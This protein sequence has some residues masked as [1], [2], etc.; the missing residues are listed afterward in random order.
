MSTVFMGSRCKSWNQSGYIIAF[1]QWKRSVFAL[2]TPSHFWPEHCNCN[3]LPVP[4]PCRTA[5]WWKS[6]KRAQRLTA[7][8]L[9][10][11]YQRAD[12]A[13]FALVRLPFSCM[14]FFLFSNQITLSL[15]LCVPVIPLTWAVT[16]EYR[17]S[18][19]VS[20]TWV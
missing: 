11:S 12:A 15:N 16:A 2:L 9:N 14:S 1:S 17:I 6:Q 3:F 18:R 13:T 4:C 10:R 20:C 8:S 7:A 19:H 5:W